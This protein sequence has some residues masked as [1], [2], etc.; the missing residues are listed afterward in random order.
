MSWA[1]SRCMRA[2]L[3]WVPAKDIVYGM[4]IA[5]QIMA[6]LQGGRSHRDRPFFWGLFRLLF[7][8]PLVCCYGCVLAFIV[9]SIINRTMTLH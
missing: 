4:Q 6:A 2:K 1:I 8:V 7:G 3:A 5:G 9:S